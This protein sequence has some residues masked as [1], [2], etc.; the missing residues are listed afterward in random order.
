MRKRKYFLISLLKSSWGKEVDMGSTI[1]KNICLY[2]NKICSAFRAVWQLGYR[3]T[4]SPKWVMGGFTLK[5]HNPWTSRWDSRHSASGNGI[6]KLKHPLEANSEVY[7]HMYRIVFDT[8]CCITAH[9]TF[10][11]IEAVMP[12]R[13]RAR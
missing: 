11:P 9:L 8:V 7:V 4:C 3:R 12:T 1:W 13:A 5:C 2:L 10:H 6:G